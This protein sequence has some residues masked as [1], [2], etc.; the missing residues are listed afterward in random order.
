MQHQFGNYVIQ[1]VLEHGRPQDRA[2]VIS[3]LCGQ[4]LHLGRHKF[5]SNVVEK[6]LTCADANS[7]QMLIDEIMTPKPEGVNPIIAMM[8]DQYANYVLQRAL[9]V[10]NGLQREALINQVRPQL[11]TMRRFSSAYS[12]HLSSIERLVGNYP[13]PAHQ[14]ISTPRLA[15]IPPDGV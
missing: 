1:Y 10:A 15:V 3:K 11:A 5:A 8:R 6:A 14:R 7:R 12:K 2:L 13:G 4:V 9:V